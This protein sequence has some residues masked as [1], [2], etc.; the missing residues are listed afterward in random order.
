M[1]R[2]VE[3]SRVRM[4]LAAV[5]LLLALDPSSVRVNAD[6][7][8]LFISEYIEGSSNNKAI[9]IYN[10]TGAAVDLLAAGYNVQMYFNGS[11]SAGLTI[12]LT[13]VVANGDVFVLAQSS[14]SAIIL[15][16]ADQTNGAGWFNGDDAVVL[17]KG[18]HDPRRRRAGRLR[19]GH[20]M[21][22]W[23]EQHR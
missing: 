20:R 4:L 15:A 1:M 16:Q 18:T 7:A 19:S 8:D 3:R 10:G 6:A 13:G 11:A 9:E 2:S 14:A 23:T 12:N 5:S 22:V 17:R 21:G